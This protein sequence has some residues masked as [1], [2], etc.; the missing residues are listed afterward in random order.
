MTQTDRQTNRQTR[1]NITSFAEVNSITAKEDIKNEQRAYLATT[2]S[3]VQYVIVFTIKV[4]VFTITFRVRW[5]KMPLRRKY[6]EHTIGSLI[7][8]IY[9]LLRGD[10]ATE[11]CDLLSHSKRVHWLRIADATRPT[12][13][14]AAAGDDGDDTEDA[15]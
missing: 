7:F 9:I 10:S 15:H 13:V 14:A 5:A 3:V 4:T 11:S 1:V 8:L 2:Y 12:V 6:K